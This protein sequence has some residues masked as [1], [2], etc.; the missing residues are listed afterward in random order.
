[1]CRVLGE[2]ACSR[3]QQKAALELAAKAASKVPHARASAEAPLCSLLVL[4]SGSRVT[5]THSNLATY[6][7]FARR[8]RVTGK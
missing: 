3:E 8:R 6:P 2:V 5:L 7:H 4:L 1:M